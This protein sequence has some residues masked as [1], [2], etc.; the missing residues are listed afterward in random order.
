MD[1][2]PCWWIIHHSG[3]F[4]HLPPEWQIELTHNVAPVSCMAVIKKGE[5]SGYGETRQSIIGCLLPTSAGPVDPHA[6]H[7]GD[8]S[9]MRHFCL[10]ALRRR[11]CRTSFFRLPEL[12]CTLVLFLISVASIALPRTL[13]SSSSRGIVRSVC[14]CYGVVASLATAS[15]T[16]S[17]AQLVYDNELQVVGVS[18]SAANVVSSMDEESCMPHKKLSSLA[19]LIKMIFPIASH[20][21]MNW[22]ALRCT[23]CIDF[24]NT[25]HRI[26]FLSILMR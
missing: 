15:Q 16:P 13:T 24:R 11:P 17:R 23:V 5:T 3:S 21:F 1:P 12:F 20:L 7:S 10:A 4:G 6:F 19:D 9:W 25:R 26:C 2:N 22:R 8:L 18:T 14:D